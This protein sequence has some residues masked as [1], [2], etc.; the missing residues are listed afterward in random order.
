MEI[1]IQIASCSYAETTTTDTPITNLVPDIVI[2][3]TIL[4]AITYR[5]IIKF[6]LN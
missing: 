5:L 2:F 6:D 1:F 3:I 4:F